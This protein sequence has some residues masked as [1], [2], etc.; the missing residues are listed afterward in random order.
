MFL[1][2]IIFLQGCNAFEMANA[3]EAM[4]G[5]L[6]AK[7]ERE[8]REQ[9]GQT[10]TLKTT[11]RGEVIESHIDGTFEGWDGDTIFKLDNGQIWQQASYAY[12]YHYA[13]RP[14]VVIYRTTGGWNMKVEGV[15]DTI[16]V[17]RLK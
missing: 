17:K 7:R 11:L 16:Y 10:T 15:D 2:I 1:A 8:A 3:A 4:R 13:Y 6:E 14:K 9:Y 12:T 5:Y